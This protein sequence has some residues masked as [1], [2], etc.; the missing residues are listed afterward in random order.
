MTRRKTMRKIML[1]LW[2]DRSSELFMPDGSPRSGA[3]IRNRFWDG[4]RGNFE[5]NAPGLIPARGTPARECYDA[6][7]DARK[8][9]KAGSLVLFQT[10][11]ISN[12]ER[13]K[14]GS[15]RLKDKPQQIK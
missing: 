9:A 15:R 14:W 11:S 2:R 6:G 5:G 8:E 7:R 12:L 4:F 3:N 1:D 10:T 13:P